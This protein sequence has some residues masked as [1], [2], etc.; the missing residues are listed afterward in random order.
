M[1]MMSMKD[2]E[3]YIKGYIG[4]PYLPLESC[5]PRMPYT[6]R[7]KGERHSLCIVIKLCMNKNGQLCFYD[8][9]RGHM[10]DGKV[11]KRLPNGLVFDGGPFGKPLI[12]KP[13]TLEEFDAYYR[14]DWPKEVSDLLHTLDDVYV[15]YRK[16]A[17]LV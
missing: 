10:L 11:L 2:R 15:W 8:Y 12:F 17:R 13:L 5:D 4:K 7:I 6:M 1:N 3:Q 9:E 14:Q 16:Q